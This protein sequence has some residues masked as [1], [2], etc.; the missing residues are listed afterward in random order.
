MPVLLRSER[1]SLRLLGIA[2]LDAVHA[3][4]ASAAHTIGA[5]PVTER[6]AT[7]RW[8]ERRTILHGQNGLAWYGVWDR[9]EGFVGTCGAFLGRCGQAPEIGYEIA[10]LRRG[11]GYAAE[12][13][14]VVT[15]GVHSTGHPCVWATIRPENGASAR[16]VLANGYRLVRSEADGKGPLDYYAHGDSATAPTNAS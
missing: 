9:G 13:V 11:R 1:L 16:V 2:D 14:A 8:L 15:S 5:G 10:E 6:E 12:A 3:L 4:F 7:M